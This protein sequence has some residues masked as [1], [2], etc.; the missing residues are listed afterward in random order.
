MAIVLTDYDTIEQD[1]RTENWSQDK[2]EQRFKKY[3]DWTIG[4]VQKCHP[5]KPTF[6]EAG[7][8]L[9]VLIDEYQEAL[10]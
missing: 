3:L 1:A 6:D 7:K 10:K 8:M 2:K 4:W 5:D 9:E